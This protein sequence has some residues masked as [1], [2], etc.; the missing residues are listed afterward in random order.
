[1]RASLNSRSASPSSEILPRQEK[2]PIVLIAETFGLSQGGAEI[3]MAR[4]VRF[5]AKAG[6]PVRI[7]VRRPCSDTF[8]SGV[9]MEVVPTMRRFR[10]VWEH[11]FAHQVAKRMGS[12]CE[13]VLSTMPLPGVS[14]YQ[15]HSGLYQAA[16][17]AMH[18]SMDPGIARGLYSMGNGLN[19]RRRSLLRMQEQL[20][21]RIPP[22]HVMTF[23]RTFR[24]QLLNAYP[25][26]ESSLVTVPLGVDLD[27][28][29]P[30]R[31]LSNPWR[32]E[33]K[34]GK[35]VL[36][37]AAHNFRLKGLACLLPALRDALRRGL[38]AELLVVGNTQG[39]NRSFPMLARHLG[40]DSHVR[41]LGTI[42]EHDMGRLYRSCDALVHPTFSDHC[43]LVVMEALASG[44][45]VITTRQNGAAELM[46][47][48]KQGFI[49][50]YPNDF[51]ALTDALLRLQD[52]DKLAEMSAAAAS[53]RPQ[54]DFAVHAREALAWLTGN[55]ETPSS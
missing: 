54:M 9:Q 2:C 38:N 12:Q 44:L 6:H 47:S 3:Y 14:H 24:A 29:R 32:L 55:Y 22:P 51:R 33:R 11:R 48:G 46:E 49:L 27:Q 43:S 18:N 13:V 23:S 15:P 16:F 53:L 52:R 20:L 39:Q 35:L 17:D 1:M 42:R 37:F 7:Y 25:S 4:L 21:T 50:D 8:D 31:E 10:I 26:L 28:F 30:G 41:F 40:L 34:P 5:L 19:L 45:P 36:L